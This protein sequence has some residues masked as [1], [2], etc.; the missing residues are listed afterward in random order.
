VRGDNIACLFSYLFSYGS[1]PR[2]WGQWDAPDLTEQHARFTPTCVGTMVASVTK[3]GDWAVHPH[4][5]GD[6]MRG[7]RVG[8]GGLGSPPRAW[9]QLTARQRQ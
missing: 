6:N 1:P 4:V 5:R 3:T 2:A 8:I 9:G 7:Q